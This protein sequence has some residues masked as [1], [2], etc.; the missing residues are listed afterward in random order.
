MDYCSECTCFYKENCHA[1]YFPSKFA[2]GF[3][4]D[5]TNIPECDYDGHDCCKSP[6][7][8]EFCTNCSCVGEWKI[9]GPSI[10]H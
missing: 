3:C 4:H 1:G 6:L 7:N 5:E 10:A 8:T 2:D 9:R